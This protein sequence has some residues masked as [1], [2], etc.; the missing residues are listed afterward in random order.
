MRI[1]H[2]T[3]NLPLPCREQHNLG[4]V[5]IM[6]IYDTF[7]FADPSER[8][9]LLAKLNIESEL[10]SHWF[11]VDS[12]F[13]NTGKF[14][15]HHVRGVLDHPDFSKFQSRI[16]VIE[17]DENFFSNSQRRQGI[18]RNFLTDQISYGLGRFS[19]FA[20][21]Q[22]HYLRKATQ[23]KSVTQ[24]LAYLYD[25]RFRHDN[26]T[27]MRTETFY[28]D[29]SRKAILD[30]V[31][32][33][34]FL[35]ISDVDEIL[36]AQTPSCKNSLLELTNAGGKYKLMRLV[37]RKRLWDWNN[38]DTS[39][40]SYVPLVSGSYIRKNPN[41]KF[42]LIRQT[43]NAVTPFSPLELVHE[44]SSC[45]PMEG[46]L[47]KYSYH[48]DLSFTQKE[49]LELSLKLNKNVGMPGLKP[50]GW[51]EF[52]PLELDHQPEYV[53]NNFSNLS[54]GLVD[55]DYRENRTKYFPELFN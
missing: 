38:L 31:G 36:D 2:P 8:E 43:Q 41:F 35:F 26:R 33:D 1:V 21:H 46:L 54:T 52:V 32:D 15:G 24:F 50:N 53:K 14:K 22:A 40:F 12:A 48:V 20:R 49:E 28:R 11:I 23:L 9:V 13:S 10:V 3:A 39:S 5:D 16:T 45:Y 47:A 51:L 19:R 4:A 30:F 17:Y 29:L 25:E 44:Y 37:K 18:E 55:K 7:L 34:D 42:N 6:S 27:Y